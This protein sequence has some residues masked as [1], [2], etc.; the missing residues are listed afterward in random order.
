MVDVVELLRHWYA[1]DSIS[2]VARGQGLDRKTVRKYVGRAEAAGLS[3]GGPP[4]TPEEWSQRVTTWFPELTDERCRSSVHGEIARHHAYITEL[5]PTTTPT[6]IHQRLRDEHGLT[7]SLSSF[8]RYVHAEFAEAVALAQVTVL[9][10][11]PPP[12]EEAQLDYGHLGY[13]PDPKTGRRH[14]VW[15]L[16]LVLAFSRHLFLFPVLRMTQ[17]EFILAHVAAFRYFGGVPR[18][19]VCDNLGAGVLKPDL[20]D[21]RLN[22]G[23]AEL[24][25]HY[26]C[27]I[28]PARV[29]HPKDKPRVERIIPYARDSFF[30]GRTFA[31]LDELRLA[32]EHWSRAVAGGRACRPLGGATPLTLFRAQER[33]ALLALPARCFEAA[34]WQEAKVAP[35]AHIS[36]AGALYSVPWTLIGRRVS[37][38][39]T[40]TMVFCYL[41]QQLVK[42]HVRVA[43]GRRQTDWQ[44]Y[45]PEKTAFFQRTPVWCRR[46]AAELG[47]AVV[48]VVEELLGVQALHRLRAAQGVLALADAHGAERL[49]AACRLALEVGDPGYRTIRGILRSG[50]ECLVPEEELTLLAPAHLHGPATLFAHLEVD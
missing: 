49:D 20:Y 39:L 47:P 4:L 24:S 16:A 45:P 32:A 22:R 25:H 10:D 29:R 35:D 14:R 50:R 27:L 3:P 33:E 36:V 31:S 11:D 13:W 6:T 40:D 46:R 2:E 34:S 42:S 12:G 37:V 15:G 43:K 9:R 18:R 17:R 5:L 1:G 38:R 7:V 26:G 44:D 21:P 8:R 48:R 30:S 23:Y 19:L 41:D 28:D